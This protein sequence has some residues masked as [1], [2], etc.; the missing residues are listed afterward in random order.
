MK[1]F[2]PN[3]FWQLWELR[4]D[5]QRSAWAD[6]DKDGYMPKY[7]LYKDFGPEETRSL[8]FIQNQYD[9]DTFMSPDSIK[10]A[11]GAM[12]KSP[13]S[14]RICPITTWMMPALMAFLMNMQKAPLDNVAVRWALALALDLK[15]VGINSLSG[16]F[17]SSPLP[18]AD[19]QV[20]H[21]VYVEPLWIG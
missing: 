12:T 14:R 15:M 13:P 3:G 20:K 17:L 9:V 2:D 5:W 11:Q 19:T 7:V 6:L 8:S 4:E 18:L 1:E 21:P 16:E 10:A